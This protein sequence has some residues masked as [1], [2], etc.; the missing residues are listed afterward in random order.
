MTARYDDPTLTQM[1]CWGIFAVFLV[2]LLIYSLVVAL[3]YAFS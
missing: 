2:V 1:L 3:S